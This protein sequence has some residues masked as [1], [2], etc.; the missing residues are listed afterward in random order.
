M[1]PHPL[2]TINFV[3]TDGRFDPFIR[4]WYHVPR[5]GDLIS[6][7]IDLEAHLAIGEVEGVIWTDGQVTVRVRSV[8]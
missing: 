7:A 6:I 2:M 4:Q 3:S 5:V 1:S 8:S